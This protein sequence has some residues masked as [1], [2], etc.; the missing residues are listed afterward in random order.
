MYAGGRPNKRNA[1]IAVLSASPPP[2]AAIAVLSASLAKK[3]FPMLHP[4]QGEKQ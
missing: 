2:N 3:A 4:P 1:A